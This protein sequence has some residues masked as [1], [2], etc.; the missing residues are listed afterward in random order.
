MSHSSL[1]ETVPDIARVFKYSNSSWRV[2]PSN[3][4]M[5][6]G[7][8]SIFFFNQSRIIDKPSQSLRRQKKT[9]APSLPPPPLYPPQFPYTS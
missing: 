4:I 6:K 9:P 5:Q 3:K 2:K 7:F 1:S 8:T